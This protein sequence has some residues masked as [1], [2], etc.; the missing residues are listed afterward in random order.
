MYERIQRTFMFKLVLMHI[1]AEWK[2][3][4]LLYDSICYLA[5]KLANNFLKCRSKFS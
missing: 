5:E 2:F 4:Y 3:N 1:K